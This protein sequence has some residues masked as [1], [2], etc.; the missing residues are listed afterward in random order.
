[1]QGR[2]QDIAL[3][4]HLID[5]IDQ[6]TSNDLRLTREEIFGSV[7]VAIPWSDEAEVLRLANDCHYCLA[8]YVFSRNTSRG[9]RMAHEI[10]SGWLRDNQGK[11][12]IMGQHDRG[13]K[14]SG[15]GKEMSLGSVLDGFSRS[16]TVTVNLSL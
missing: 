14:Q 16:K 6:G 7:L 4:D 12:Q 1:L 10:A 8:G 9:I 5:R 13:F 11:G 3:I 2:R 15:V